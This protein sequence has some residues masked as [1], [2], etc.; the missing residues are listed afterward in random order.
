MFLVQRCFLCRVSLPFRPCFPFAHGFILGGFHP[1]YTP[2]FTL[3]GI[4]ILTLS[5]V[6]DL[7]TLCRKEGSGGLS[8]GPAQHRP[9][10]K[11][12]CG[13]GASFHRSAHCAW[14]GRHSS[15]RCAHLSTMGDE[16]SAHRCASQPWENG[17][18]SAPRCLT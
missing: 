3:S 8:A 11:R 4:L 6:P 2:R 16:H 15:H 18:H 14:A 1:G 17:G 5:Y 12:E 9:T 7:S 13:A 10:V